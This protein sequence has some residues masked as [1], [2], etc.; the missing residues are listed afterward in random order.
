MTLGFQD[1]FVVDES[2]L[3][4]VVIVQV[5]CGSELA[6]VVVLVVVK[7]VVI[8]AVDVAGIVAIFVVN[9]VAVEVIDVAA[10]GKQRIMFGKLPYVD[11]YSLKLT[12]EADPPYLQ[13]VQLPIP[14]P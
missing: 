4:V 1:Q 11:H 9:A 12:V 6:V 13:P 10:V 3:A 14:I 8:F 5:W 7:D 2:V